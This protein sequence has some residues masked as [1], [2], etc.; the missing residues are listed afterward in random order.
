MSVID[1]LTCCVTSFHRSERLARALESVWQ[2]GIRRLAVCSP[3]AD[4]EVL[5][6]L[7]SFR[8]RQW[9]SFDVSTTTEDIGLNNTW[10]VAA[11]LARTKRILVLHDD[12]TLAPE[13][14]ETYESIIGPAMDKRDAGFVSWNAAHKFD[15]GHTEPCPYWEGPSTLMPSSHLLKVV[16]N[17]QKFCLSPI[18]SVLNR[19]IL[20]RACK[21]AGETLVTNSVN[22]SP[23]VLLGTETLVYLR[24]IQ[25]FKRWLYLDKVLS[26]YGIH[27]GSGTC[28]AE[29]ANQHQAWVEGYNVA[30]DQAKCPV[31]PATPRL[32]LVHADY[33]FT[34]D[35]DRERRQHARFSWDFHFN[36]GDMI[37]LQVHQQRADPMKLRE[38]I[39]RGCSMALP[40]DIVVYANSDAGLTTQA[41]EL[42]IAGV[43]RGNGVTY[44]SNR[45]LD[46]K[47]GRLYKTLTTRKA[48]GGIEVVAVTPSW[49]AAHRDKMPD[50]FVG[51]E[52]WDNCFAALAEEWAD[53]T[54][55]VLST[56]DQR[57]RSKAHS[58]NVCW[59]KPHYSEWRKERTTSPTQV[60]N[61]R[62]AHEFFLARGDT[63]AASWTA[64]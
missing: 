38:L 31:P 44:C 29:K 63:L 18:V 19:K 1:G 62:L 52:A 6:V 36:N 56:H 34:D 26:F 12:D 57:L 2:A 15:D 22:C 23:G 20:I 47:P 30:R 35:A 21:E 11:Y 46:P 25:A 48:P 3:E 10:M 37:E 41:A 42:L 40:E 28:M 7:E 39:D 43:A 24:H 4:A 53:G 27:E 50:M 13:F 61:R 49:W 51:C 33:P 60:H 14:G 32:I 58:D 16:D 54:K 8:Q 55:E 5:S 45:A 17:R 59:H 64:E 9:L